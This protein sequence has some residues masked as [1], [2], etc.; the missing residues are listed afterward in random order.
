MAQLDDNLGASQISFSDEQL[1][2]LNEVSKAD[3]HYPYRFIKIYGARTPNPE[4]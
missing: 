1:N 3:E 4:G 2:R